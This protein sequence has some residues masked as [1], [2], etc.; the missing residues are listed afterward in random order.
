VGGLELDSLSGSIVPTESEPGTYEV[1]FTTQGR[2]PTVTTTEVII[3]P[4]AQPGS[5][6]E[7]TDICITEP[8]VE[9]SDFIEDEDE[10]GVFT[11]ADNEEVPSA[12][13]PE[14]AGSFE[15]TYTVQSEPCQD[16][17]ESVTINVIGEPVSGEVVEN[18]VICE[19]A[20]EIVLPAFLEGEQGNGQWLDADGNMVPDTVSVGS[21]GQVN[22]TYA[23]SNDACGERTTEVPINIIAQ[24]NSGEALSETTV[25][26]GEDLG[27]M[28]YLSGA[29]LD[30][31]WTNENGNAIEDNYSFEEAGSFVLTYTVE[32]VPCEPSSTEVTFEAFQ[33]SNSGT[34]DNPNGVCTNE[35]AFNL[36]S[37]LSGADGDGIWMDSDSNE[38]SGIFEPESSGVFD[39]TYSV[40]SPECE[41]INT[42]VTVSVSDAFCTD[43][44]VIVPEGFSPN[45]DGIGDQWIINALEQFPGNRLLVFNRWGN[46]VYSAQPYTNDWDGK[47]Q[48]GVNANEPLPVGTYY[49]VLNLGD[50]SGP[51]KGYIYINR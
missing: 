39:Y 36:I 10:G 25:C 9:L 4:L 5:A 7:N 37:L 19:D 2:C 45:D 15:F 26:V 20:T 43:N 29:D 24:P 46:K 8:S 48:S 41:N 30:G 31:F 32:N 13:N 12:F 51:R 14:I 27:L 28:N 38:V 22:Y 35:P 3:V 23:V 42:E 49:Y 34:A 18:N 1:I 17:S 40:S 6:V 16:Q 33:G 21:P 44:T 11:N 50:G 47:A